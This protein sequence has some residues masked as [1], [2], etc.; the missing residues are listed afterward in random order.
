M[1]RDGYF[2]VDALAEDML[3]ACFADVHMHGSAESAATYFLST[4]AKEPLG[5]SGKMRV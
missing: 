4:Q 2:A 1:A 3:D 5:L